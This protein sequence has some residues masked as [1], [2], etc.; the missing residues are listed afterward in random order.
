M[1]RRKAII[2]LVFICLSLMATNIL[3]IDP[4]CVAGMA[5]YGRD[6]QLIDCFEDL[7]Q[8]CERCTLTIVVTPP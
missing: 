5:F 4:K 2:T 3:A 8:D 1:R 7:G 6:G